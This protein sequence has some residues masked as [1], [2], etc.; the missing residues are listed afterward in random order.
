M[1]LKKKILIAAVII[2]VAGGG[3]FPLERFI[4]DRLLFSKSEDEIYAQMKKVS[5]EKLVKIINRY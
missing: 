5:S 1:K 2:A 4:S 3:S